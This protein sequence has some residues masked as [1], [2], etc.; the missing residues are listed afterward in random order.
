MIDSGLYGAAG[1]H[2]KWTFIEG[3]LRGKPGLICPRYDSC[4]DLGREREPQ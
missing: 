3:L 2:G 4:A 1:H